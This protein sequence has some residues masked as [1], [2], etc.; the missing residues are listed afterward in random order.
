MNFSQ[1]NLSKICEVLAINGDIVATGRI[2]GIT[3]KNIKITN[4]VGEMA[5]LNGNM[6]VKLLVHN[7]ESDDEIFVALVCQSTRSE[8]CLS[9]VELLANFEKREYFRVSVKIDTKFYINDGTGELDEVKSSKV[10]VR[11]LSLRG[12]LLITDAVLE[13]DQKIYIVLPFSKPEIFKCIVKRKVEY[14]RSVGYG[15]EFEKYSSQQE[16]LLC[17]Y[18]FEEQ[19]KMILKAKRY[20]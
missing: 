16:D 19:R 6:L 18:I 15:C 9:N 1:Q 17:Q 5:L 13:D 14:L 4:S 7:N 10:K 11:D 8:L 20:D 3:D 2:S 12:A